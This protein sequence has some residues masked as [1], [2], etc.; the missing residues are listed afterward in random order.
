MNK[1]GGDRQMNTRAWH[2]TEDKL[3]DGSP[4]P[5]IREWLEY[6][7]EIVIC[8]TGLHASRDPFDA[9]QYAPGPMLHLV[10]CDGIH[11]EHYDKLVCSR[12]RIIA[13]KDV[14]EGLRYFARMKALSVVHLWTAPDIYIEFLVTGDESIRDAAFDAAW[15]AARTDAW[16]AAWDAAK[17]AASAAASADAWDAAWAAAWDAARAAAWDAARAA[18]LDAAW[19]AAWDAARTAARKQFNDLV[20]EAFEEW[21]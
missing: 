14:T 18:A 7:G 8:E 19:A 9:L 12:R 20:N 3:R 13:S 21:L 1:P 2:F 4:I 5:K 10:E 16:D 11:T 6:D 15:T 17:A